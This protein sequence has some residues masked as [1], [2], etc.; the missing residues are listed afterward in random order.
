M[1]YFDFDFCFKFIIYLAALFW[2]KLLS[3][4][5]NRV[6]C[7]KAS[8]KIECSTMMSFDHFNVNQVLINYLAILFEIN[9]MKIVFGNFCIYWYPFSKC[10]S[11]V[12]GHW[13]LVIFSAGRVSESMLHE[14]WK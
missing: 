4:I 8:I 3:Q 6:K 10:W 7:H 1:K 12:I 9:E 11:L 14:Y 13:P 5:K 2:I